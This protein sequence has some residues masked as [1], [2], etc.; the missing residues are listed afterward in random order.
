MP[1]EFT[2]ESRSRL[3]EACFTPAGAYPW[4]FK[5]EAEAALAEIDRL[6]VENNES[7]VV[8]VFDAEG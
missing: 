8:Q 6:E 2:P 3:E 7:H 1:N 5:E 4:A